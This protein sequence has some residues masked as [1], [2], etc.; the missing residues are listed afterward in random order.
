[1]TK[2]DR[3]YA[4][5]KGESCVAIGTVTEIAEKTNVSVNSVYY[6]LMPAYRRKQEKRKAGSNIKVMIEIEEDKMMTVTSV[7]NPD[8]MA[9]DEHN[10]IHNIKYDKIK[11]KP[12][13]GCE[14]EEQDDGYY[15]VL[16][17]NTNPD[18]AGGVCPVR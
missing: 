4:L 15:Q 16:T 18:C 13:P 14:L 10:E 5:Y 9:V 1:M 2:M 12:T 11:G 17:N 7:N 3:I 6:M 8:V